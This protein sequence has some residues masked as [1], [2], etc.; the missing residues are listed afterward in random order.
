MAWWRAYIDKENGDHSR[1]YDWEADHPSGA[2]EVDK[3]T[4]SA[5]PPKLPEAA[6]LKKSEY[7][8]QI[9]SIQ[10]PS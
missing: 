2:Y 1:V 10:E 9:V 5:V 8:G 4:G 6:K 7:V 3:T